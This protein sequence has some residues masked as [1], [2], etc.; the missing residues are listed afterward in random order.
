MVEPKYDPRCWDDWS[1]GQSDRLSRHLCLNR[2]FALSY[3]YSN[4]AF[5]GHTWRRESN[6]KGIYVTESS[7]EAD[8]VEVAKKKMAKCKTLRYYVILQLI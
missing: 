2:A 4:S 3:P 8:D 1:V 7:C 5:H 6:K